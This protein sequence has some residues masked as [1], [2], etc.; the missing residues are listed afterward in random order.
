MTFPSLFVYST[1][2]FR[3]PNE[4]S[5]LHSLVLLTTL[6]QF[7]RQ[8]STSI[9]QQLCVEARYLSLLFQFLYSLLIPLAHPHPHARSQLLM[10][11]FQNCK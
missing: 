3:V 9:F 8:E 11:H 1:L 5:R 10:T 2:F 7:I 4:P 6:I